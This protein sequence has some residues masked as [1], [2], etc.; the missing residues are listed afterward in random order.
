MIL[1]GDSSD[2]PDETKAY[3]IEVASMQ[4]KKTIDN[5]TFLMQCFDGH[6]GFTDGKPVFLATIAGMQDVLDH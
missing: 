1:G 2:K 6:Y 4:I 5:L 3:L